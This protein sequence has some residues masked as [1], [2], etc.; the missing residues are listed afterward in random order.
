MTCATPFPLGPSQRE[1]ETHYSLAE[2]VDVAETAQRRTGISG[3]TGR[4]SGYI[5][6]RVPERLF[7]AC[8]VST[9]MQS[10]H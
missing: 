7:Q 6:L 1:G 2:T 3:T 9:D 8:Q 4:G 5:V 10:I